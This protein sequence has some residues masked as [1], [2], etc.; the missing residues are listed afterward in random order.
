MITGITGLLGSYLAKKLA[1]EAQTIGNKKG[2]VVLNA[3]WVDWRKTFIGRKG[4]SPMW[5]SW[6][7]A[8]RDQDI[9]IHAAGLVS[10]DDS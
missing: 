6:R 2:R 1:S 9:V 3:Y 4:K 5:N 8:C 7:R 10:F